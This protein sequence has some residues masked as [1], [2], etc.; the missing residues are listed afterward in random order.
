VRKE[1]EIVASELYAKQQALRELTKRHQEAVNQAVQEVNDAKMVEAQDRLN[2]LLPI[3]FQLVYV[4]GSNEISLGNMGYVK[5]FP[6]GVYKFF[7]KSE[8]Y[9]IPDDQLDVEKN[10]G[11]L[12]KSICARFYEF[13]DHD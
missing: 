6:N 9:G 2:I 8:G 7:S 12:L 3:L 13:L 10:A 5:R 4:P 1:G 11:N